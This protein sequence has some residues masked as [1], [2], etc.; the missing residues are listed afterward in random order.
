MNKN[1]SKSQEE[2]W[3]WKQKAYE[4][5]QHLPLSEQIKNIVSR[6]EKMH[7]IILEKKKLLNKHPI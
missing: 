3:H 7:Q 1:I 4:S 2:V 5:V 6:T